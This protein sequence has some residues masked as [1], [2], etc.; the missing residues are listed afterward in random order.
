MPLTNCPDCEKQVSTNAESCPGC[1]YF[2]RAF[3][4]PVVVSRK[5]LEVT[6]A[7]GVLIAWIVAGLLG[8]FL[9]FL[10]TAR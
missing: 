3:E 6:I 9:F 8:A 1:G 5:G 4:R 7:G 10:V 2:F